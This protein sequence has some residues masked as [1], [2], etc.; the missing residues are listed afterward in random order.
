MGQVVKINGHPVFSSPAGAGGVVKHQR[1]IDLVHLA[2]QTG[3]NR[4]LE[5]EVLQMFL[6]QSASLARQFPRM[7]DAEAVK[8]A[9][10]SIK[11]AARS[12]GAIEV[13]NC[14]DKLE[15]HP[16]EKKNVAALIA[17]ID[18]T[19]DYIASLLR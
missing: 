14:A 17:E 19:C 1:P 2:H 5:E 15:E 13:A 18:V 16:N 6:R 12:V 9:A 11:G 3:G 7:V 4:A 10:H 8:Q